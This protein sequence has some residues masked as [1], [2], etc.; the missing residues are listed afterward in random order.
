MVR[1][2]LG[3]RQEVAQRIVG[4]ILVHELV[5]GEHA[6]H[7]SE[8]RVAVGLGFRHDLGPDYSVRARTI[9]DNDLLSPSLA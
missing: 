9:V 1:G 6:H 2:E 7:A 3:Y 5:Y 8:Q 4:Q